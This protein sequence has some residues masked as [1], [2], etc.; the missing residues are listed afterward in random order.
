MSHLPGRI[1]QCQKSKLPHHIRWHGWDLEDATPE[2][3]AAVTA[4]LCYPLPTRSALT[5]RPVSRRSANCLFQIRSSFQ[6]H[7]S[8][9][10]RFTGRIAYVLS[11]SFAASFVRIQ[12]AISCPCTTFPI[13]F[14]F[15]PPIESTTTP[16]SITKS[17]ILSANVGLSNRFEKAST[18]SLSVKAC[19]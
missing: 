14:R 6:K 8:R 7:L 5:S 10:V 4:I 12:I 17:H 15:I 13:T 18:A 19:L 9:R 3:G 1:S 2:P 16:P 11:R